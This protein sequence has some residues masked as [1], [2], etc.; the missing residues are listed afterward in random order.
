MTDPHDVRP[1]S[2]E[3]TPITDLVNL[4]RRYTEDEWLHAY[5]IAAS[6]DVS[7]L[8]MAL[9]IFRRGQ[10]DVSADQPNTGEVRPCPRLAYHKY[11]EYCSTCDN[12]EQV[13]ISAVSGDEV[14]Q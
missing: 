2:G 6:G 7:D 5:R 13:Y 1:I 12:T 9:A 3:R 11:T 10:L 4:A 14:E 8:C